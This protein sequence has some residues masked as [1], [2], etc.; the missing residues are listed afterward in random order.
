MLEIEDSHFS[1]NLCSSFLK[2]EC[3]DVSAKEIILASDLN[4][5]TR[6]IGYVNDL[7]IKET[8]YVIKKPIKSKTPISKHKT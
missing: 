4:Y 1:N 8:A 3:W 6:I 2:S 5:K 7:E